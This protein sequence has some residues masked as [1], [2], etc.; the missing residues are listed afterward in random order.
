[1]TIGSRADNILSIAVSRT[2]CKFFLQHSLGKPQ[3]IDVTTYFDFVRGGAP[4][5]AHFLTL[6]ES[7][8]NG[9][10]FFLFDPCIMPPRR[11]DL[12]PKMRRV[13]GPPAA[14]DVTPLAH[15]KDLA[16]WLG[17]SE[18]KL[19]WLADLDKRQRKTHY[20]CR[21]I[22]KRSGMRLIE[23]PKAML[24]RVQRQILREMLHVVPASKRAHGFVRNRDV[25]TFVG[26]HVGQ[27]ICL[28]MDLRNFFPSIRAGRVYRLFIRLGYPLDVAWLL[29]GLCT[30]V[31][32]R[33]TFE[34]LTEYPKQNELV[35][36]YGHRH[37]P[38]GAPT[39]PALSNFCAYRMDC[40]LSGLA[41]AL[42]GHY[43]RYADD[44]LFSFDEKLANDRQARNRMRRLAQKVAVIVL[45]E[46]FD[47][48]FR[49][50]R[51]MLKSQR[52]MCAGIVINK[53]TNLSRAK[54]DQLRAVLYNCVKHGP[55]SQNL[56]KHADFRSHLAGKIAWVC[57]LNS[58]RSSKLAELFNQVDW[59]S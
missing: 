3:R 27:P 21:W 2:V 17:V 23:S 8:W 34:K 9:D 5:V 25:K 40:R 22:R 52:Q 49:K 43:T 36:T 32:R 58:A 45:E 54:F 31:T 16:G 24:K 11:I 59:D 14:W 51:I 20:V 41:E 48:N 30:T 1:M 28:K 4:T 56:R 33:A 13:T 15:R 19:Y 46:G 37:L 47:V 38:Q 55:V 50:T 6:D 53:T 44:L 26:A 35:S 12:K 42:G 18:S 7:G 10:H 39:S 29:T 57:H